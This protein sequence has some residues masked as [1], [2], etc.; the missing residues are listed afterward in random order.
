MIFQFDFT[1]NFLRPLA[2]SAGVLIL[3]LGV[4]WLIYAFYE[5][6][7]RGSY[8]ERKVEDWDFKIT[9]FLKI[10]TYLGFVVGILCIICGVGGLILNEPPSVAFGA[11]QLN[12]GID[13]PTASVFT[14]AVLIILGLLTFLKP[15]NDLPIGSVIGLL[16][17]S[18]VVIITASAIPQSA[19]DVIA[20]F[21]DPRLFFIILFIVIFA[22]VA[23]TVKFY[24]GG[25]MKVS[26]VISWPPIAFV[27]ALFCFIQGILLLGAGISIS[28]F[29]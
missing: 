26:K 28:G 21:I 1:N 9:R 18:A 22:I 16:A 20:V 13:P 24:I 17:A 23:L 19:I 8:K 3:I 27:I 7:R 2:Q 10:L 12:Q 4:I 15:V 6:K 29:F 14:S 5:G 25:L 11:Q